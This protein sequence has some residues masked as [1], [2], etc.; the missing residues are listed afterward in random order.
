MSDTHEVTKEVDR[1]REKFAFYYRYERPTCAR[2]DEK[3]VQIHRCDPCAQTEKE[4]I[5][6]LS[7][8]ILISNLFSAVFSL[9]FCPVFQAAITSAELSAI[10]DCNLLRQPSLQQTFGQSL[11]DKLLRQPS[12]QQNF[13][14]SLMTNLS[15]KPSLQQ[16]FGQSLMTIFKDSHHF[17]RSLKTAITSAE[18][19][20]VFDDNL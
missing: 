4:Y 18:L 10:F 2:S 1:P 20:A 16:N 12:L 11:I 17:S 13:G 7:Q 19:W 3:V 9:V 14:Q 15:R 6:T 8:R 5:L